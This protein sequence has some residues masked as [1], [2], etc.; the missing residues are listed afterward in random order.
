MP[1]I[2]SSQIRAGEIELPCA[3]LAETLPFFSEALGFSL[4]SVFPA[5]APRTAVL[6]GYG[7]RLRLRQGADGPPGV[8]RLYCDEPCAVAAE[9]RLIAPN[10]TVIELLPADAPPALPAL[11]A[12]YV[13]SRLNEADGFGAGRA[14]MQYRDLIPGRQGGRFIASHIRIEQGG[15]VPDYVHFH[16]V[17]FQLIYCYKGWVRVVYEDQG[18]PFTMHAG[19]CVLQ[20]PQIRHRVLESSAGLEVIEVSCPAE[21]ETLVEHELELPTPELNPARDFGGQRFVRHE[22]D[23]AA[24][25]AWR[26]GGFACRDTGLADGSGGRVSARVVQRAGELSPAEQNQG[27]ELQFWF[28]LRG[29]LSIGGPAH[30]NDD[31]TAGDACV[32][33]ASMPFSLANCSDELEFLEVLAPAGQ[34]P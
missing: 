13:V 15:P 19:D 10:G 2:D 16:K 12:S 11:D 1:T 14:G 34:A 21:H 30:G 17:R 23:S 5:D 9:Q 18:P 26:I 27:A 28:V 29:S 7:L 8:L 4:V 22:A 20:P 24:W 33:P 3:E 6:E 32:I 25:D 31:L